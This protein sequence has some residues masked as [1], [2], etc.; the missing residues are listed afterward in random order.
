MRIIMPRPISQINFRS[1]SIGLG[2]RRQTFILDEILELSTVGQH[3]VLHE[4]PGK[5]LLFFRKDEIL[6]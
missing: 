2:L 5:L 1:V 3:L 6:V 4:R